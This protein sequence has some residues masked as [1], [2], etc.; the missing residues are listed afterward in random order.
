ML[1]S[2]HK[3]LFLLFCSVILFSLSHIAWKIIIF[4]HFH[5][6]NLS[7]PLLF[8]T[9]ILNIVRTKG[10]YLIVKQKTKLQKM[11]EEGKG[12][13]VCWIPTFYSKIIH[14]GILIQNQEQIMICF[15]P[16]FY[17][18][19]LVNHVRNRKYRFICLV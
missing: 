1:Q 15:V 10:F 7:W 17:I 12:K 9:F 13:I 2:K 14:D 18:I 11:H 16:E 6:L 3:T 4:T 5:V 19:C 8:S